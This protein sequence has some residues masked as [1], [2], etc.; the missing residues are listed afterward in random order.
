MRILLDP[1]GILLSVATWIFLVSTWLAVHHNCLSI[2]DPQSCTFL[3]CSYIIRLIRGSHLGLC[4]AAV[5]S[6]LRAF[7]ADPGF[8]TNSPRDPPK[9]FQNAKTCTLCG[10]RW[11]PPRAHHCKTCRLCVFRMDHHCPWINNCVG[12]LN[13]KYYILFLIYTAT[14]CAMTLLCLLAGVFH[15]IFWSP[16]KVVSF[17]VILKLT[18][19]LALAVFFAFM[20]LDFLREQWEAVETNSTMVESYQLTH[21]MRTNTLNHL[22]DI[23]GS[24]WYLWPLPTPPYLTVNYTEPV[25]PELTNSKIKHSFDG[26]PMGIETES[27]HSEHEDDEVTLPG[28]VDQSITPGED[29]SDLMYAEEDYEFINSPSSIPSMLPRLRARQSGGMK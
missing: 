2:W 26:E 28:M 25:Y 6:H 27:E 1:T 23:I 21:G 20:T 8:C 18:T 7:F 10:T 15:W 9:G 16:S 24:D 13:Q 11:K 22:Y 29:D 14:Y 12:L 4:I 5:I 17:W 3:G 19:T